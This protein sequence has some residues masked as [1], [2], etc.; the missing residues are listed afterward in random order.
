MFLWNRTFLIGVAIGAVFAFMFTSSM[1]PL[2]RPGV[3]GGVTMMQ[4]ALP[5]S[6]YV[7]AGLFALASALLMFVYHQKNLALAAFGAAGGA[8]FWGAFLWMMLAVM[9]NSIRF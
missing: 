5:I 4:A 7:L 6:A 9:F 3:V 1:S 2:A 8:A